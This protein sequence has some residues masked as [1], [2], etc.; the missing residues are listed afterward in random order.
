MLLSLL[1]IIKK[2]SYLPSVKE[3]IVVDVVAQENTE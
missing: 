2:W 1:S 3:L